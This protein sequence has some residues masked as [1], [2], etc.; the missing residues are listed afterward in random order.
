MVYQEPF[1]RLTTNLEEGGIAMSKSVGVLGSFIGF[2]VG[3]IVTLFLLYLNW[4]PDDVGV[5]ILLLS[6]MSLLGGTFWKM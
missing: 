6:L 4:I 2:L 5:T 1:S 3:T